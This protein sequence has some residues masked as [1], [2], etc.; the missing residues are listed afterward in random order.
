MV[1]FHRNH[2]QKDQKMFR[3]SQKSGHF[4]TLYG[5]QD[6]FRFFV[7]TRPFFRFS[8]GNQ[9]ISRFFMETRSYSGF[10][11]YDLCKFLMEI[12]SFTRKLR[13]FRVL[14]EN[15]SSFRYF[16]GIKSSSGSS[17]KSGHIQVLHGNP[18]I[19]RFFMKVRLFSVFLRKPGY[20]RVFHGKHV[21]FIFSMEIRL[22]SSFYMESIF[23]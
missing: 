13:Y 12:R 21:I 23:K 9:V 19:H 2:L 6:I 1:G 8:H 20:N 22:I 18:S 10:R 17:R 15:Q 11:E 14:N 16:I 4:Q 7:Q 3:S 5:N